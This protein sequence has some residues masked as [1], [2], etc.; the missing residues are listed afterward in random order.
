[1]LLPAIPALAARHGR[2]LEPGNIRAQ[3]PALLLLESDSDAGWYHA[4]IEL[5]ELA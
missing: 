2:S 3:I 5:L 1:M 4:E